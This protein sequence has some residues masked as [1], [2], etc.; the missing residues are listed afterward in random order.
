MN[1]EW[2]AASIG[3]AMQNV[4]IVTRTDEVIAALDGAS[5]AAGPAPPVGS[6][7]AEAANE[8]IRRRMRERRER[9]GG[10]G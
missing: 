3:Y 7:S 4:A 5:S 9:T 2:H 6:G 1:A 8:A 10:G